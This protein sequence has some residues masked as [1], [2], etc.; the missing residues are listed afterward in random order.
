MKVI[1]YTLTEDGQTP[2]HIV[3]GGYF[4]KLNSNASPRD[5]N[6]IGL[7]ETSTVEPVLASKA[8]VL[9]YCQSFMNDYTD[10][11]LGTEYS[12]ED[13]VNQWCADKGIS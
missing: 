4:A 10:P 7:A 13:I 9:A 8:E 2:S 6:L 3:D 12:V 11:I 1:I 5:Y